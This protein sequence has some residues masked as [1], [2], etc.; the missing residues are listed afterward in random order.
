MG[1]GL[2]LQQMVLGKLDIH[3]KKKKK[4]NEVGPLHY[5]QHPKINSLWIKDLN[6]R[7]ETIKSLEENT[8]RKLNDIGLTNDFLAR[9]PKVQATDAKID[10]C[11]HIELRN[12][13][14]AKEETV[15]RQPME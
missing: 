8:G 3:I 10:K 13:Y 5:I 4:K 7:P 9:T 14:T 1:K 11:N 12:F 15:K 2:S 6:K